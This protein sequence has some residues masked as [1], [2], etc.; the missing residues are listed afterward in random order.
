MSE[1]VLGY[2]SLDHYLF[3]EG[4]IVTVDRAVDQKKS[5]ENI[6][7]NSG[8]TMAS[9]EHGTR[10]LDMVTLTERLETSRPG[11]YSSQNLRRCG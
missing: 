11:R 2:P 10:W 4:K 3:N 9:D 8:K 6:A 5:L 7:T 1:R